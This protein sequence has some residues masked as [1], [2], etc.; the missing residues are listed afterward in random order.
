[1]YNLAALWRAC[2]GMMPEA[3]A[4]AEQICADLDM[5]MTRAI[6][7]LRSMSL[8]Y[9][10]GVVTRGWLRMECQGREY[11]LE[12]DNGYID[13]PWMPQHILDI[14]SDFRCACVLVDGRHALE[15]TAVR[16]LVGMAFR[17]QGQQEACRP[18]LSPETARQLKQR[19]GEMA[20]YSHKPHCYRSAVLTHLFAVLVLD[21]LQAWDPTAA[22][23]H[24]TRRTDELFVDFLNLLPQYYADHHDITF[25]ADRLQISTAYLSRI[26]RQLTGR[27]VVDCIN[28]MLAME[29]AFLLSTTSLSVT[30]IAVRLHFADTPSFS[31]FF[32]RMKNMS[33]K[34]YRTR[35]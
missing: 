31:K 7:T 12:A 20:D 21:L 5:P 18:A 35:I 27:T 13:M 26:V 24:E 23:P 34:E 22:H 11:T 30:Q 16:Q 28:G 33:P 9:A 29:A 1:M 6:G 4:D 17:M 8:H 10:V 15:M 14:S 19:V 25:Y 3:D 32:S 2:G